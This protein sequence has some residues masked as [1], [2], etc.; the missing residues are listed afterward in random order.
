MFADQATLAQVNPIG[1]VPTL[2]LSDGFELVDSAAI[3]DAVDEM[4]GGER[5]LMPDSG[6]ARRQQMKLTAVAV[7]GCEKAVACLY[8]RHKRATDPVWLDRLEQ[9]TD[10]CL[11]WLQQHIEQMPVPSHAQIATAVLVHF[12]Q[13]YLP[14]M[15]DRLRPALLHSS[16]QAEQMPWFQAAPFESD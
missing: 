4:F 16:E 3:L 12:I 11:V 10:N 6:A 7:G 1:R 5:R 13:Q 2:I 8:E 14:E 9:Q 15:R